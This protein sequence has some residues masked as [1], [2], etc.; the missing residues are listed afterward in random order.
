M[1]KYLL[2][3]FVC[4]LISKAQSPDSVRHLLDTVITI[5]RNE[6]LHRDEVNW[7]SLKKEVYRKEL[8]PSIQTLFMSLKDG[9]GG[10]IY[11]GARYG[12]AWP[13]PAISAAMMA[14][15]RTQGP[16]KLKIS[17]LS[18]AY[19]Y[20][21]IPPFNGGSQAD[22][23]RFAQEIRDSICKLSSSKLKGWI[24][25]LRMNLGGNMWPMMA[26]LG[27]L[28]GD[29]KVGSFVQSQNWYIKNGD[30]YLEGTR[31]A[32]ARSLCQI[33]TNCKIAVLIGPL[34]QSAGEAVA[35]SLIGRQNTR[36]FGEPTGGYVTANLTHVLG[37]A[38]LM[39]AAFWEAD[40]NG[41][42]Y[43]E[44]LQPDISVDTERIIPTALQWLQ[45]IP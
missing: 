5:V 30:A 29:G 4:P 6:A 36:S 34:T 40:R 8:A 32:S 38:K 24:I 18:G 28:I 23:D 44:K 22:N 11:K 1:K 26:G 17:L 2:L 27:P 33:G 14:Q 13:V 43:K 31:L 16:P 19:G 42:I 41:H 20:I 21:L 10:L 7:D 25:D 45:D 37:Q 39:V 35:I 12:M 3:F 9:H 15:L